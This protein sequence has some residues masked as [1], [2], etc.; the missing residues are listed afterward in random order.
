MGLE[1]CLEAV[2]A[3]GFEMSTKSKIEVLT[4]VFEGI[5]ESNM[6]SPRPHS[7]N[8]IKLGLLANG[9]QNSAELLDLIHELLEDTYEFSSVISRNK[10]NA[11]RPCPPHILEELANQC[12]VVVTASGD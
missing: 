10:G 2:Q 7:L 11:S 4:P 3:G 6:V 1:T 9:K 5:S 8:K 12:D